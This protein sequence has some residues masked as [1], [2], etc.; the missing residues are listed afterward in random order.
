MRTAYTG[1]GNKPAMSLQHRYH[2]KTL[3][4]IAVIQAR[5]DVLIFYYHEFDKSCAREPQ[6][7]Q[8]GSKKWLTR[9]LKVLDLRILDFP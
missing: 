6:V 1:S 5:P 8:V 3:M 7:D 2:V 9:I 4:I